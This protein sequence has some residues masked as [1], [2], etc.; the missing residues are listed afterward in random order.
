[1]M[2]YQIMGR[3]HTVVILT[4][5]CSLGGAIVTHAQ[6]SQNTD[7]LDRTW[8]VIGDNESND[9]ENPLRFASGNSPAIGENINGIGK[10]DR[11]WLPLPQLWKIDSDLLFL[12]PL[13]KLGTLGGGLGSSFDYGPLEGSGNGSVTGPGSGSGPGSVGVTPESPGL[14]QFLAVTLPIALFGLSKRRLSA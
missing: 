11:D 7:S 8:C 4:A 1:M 2:K 14:I 12:L 5:F 13:W 9:W 6:S 3:A 10:S